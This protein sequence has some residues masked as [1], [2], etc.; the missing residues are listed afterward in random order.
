[1][2][3]LVPK[4]AVQR[5]EHR[6]DGDL[7]QRGGVPGEGGGGGGRGV[8]QGV[9]SLL[10]GPALRLWGLSHT[11]LNAHTEPGNTADMNIPELNRTNHE[12]TY[13]VISLQPFD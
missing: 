8:R 6:V 10:R 13:R 9:R 7:L 11:Q 1:M 2:S 3:F 12:Y 4:L 5:G